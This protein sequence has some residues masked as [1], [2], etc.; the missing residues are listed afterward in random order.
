MP[1]L[2]TGP[3][4][5]LTSHL[6]LQPLTPRSGDTVIFV[7]HFGLKNSKDIFQL[8]IDKCFESMPGVAAI[9]DDILVYGKT[10]QEHNENLIRVLDKCRNVGI[11]LNKD[12]LQ[13]GIQEVEYFGH[14]LSAQPI[15]VAAIKEMEPLS[16][17]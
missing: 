4:C 5:S 14:N 7:Y 16:N 8:K 10:P 15:K 3:S 6:Y 12:K 17:K 13:V 1:V 9:V 11:K 2:V